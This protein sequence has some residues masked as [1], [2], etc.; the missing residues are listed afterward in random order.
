[1][2][3]LLFYLSEEFIKYKI[4]GAELFDG[5]E[6]GRGGN[7][8]NEVFL[9][10]I[11]QYFRDEADYNN[12]VYYNEKEENYYISNMS[13]EYIRDNYRAIIMAP[14]NLLCRGEKS[15]RNVLNIANQIKKFGIPVFVL[16]LG[17]QDSLDS[18]L[19]NLCNELGECGKEFYNAV[20][21]SGGN[22]AVRGFYTKSYFDSINCKDVK[23]VGCPSM[24]INGLDFQIDEKKANIEKFKPIINGYTRT[25]SIPMIFNAILRN[26]IFIDQGAFDGALFDYSWIKKDKNDNAKYLVNKY[27]WH[28]ALLLSKRKIELF[29]DINMWRNYLQKGD[30]TFSFGERI[31][32]NIISL[33]EGI[34]SAIYVCDSRTLEMAEFFKIPYFEEISCYKNLYEVYMKSDFKEFNKQYKINCQQ[35]INH[36]KEFILI[37]D[38]NIFNK[39]VDC[40]IEDNDYIELSEICRNIDTPINRV[41]YNMIEKLKRI[42]NRNIK[43]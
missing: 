4:Y 23:V 18:G 10:A 28:G 22:I 33:T 6:E 16:G 15:K 34:Q 38:K 41:K 24:Y 21:E 11:F 13:Y 30:Y 43:Y 8:G 5:Y 32:G 26:G 39:V 2:K 29:Y 19:K 35:F 17:V 3:K 31:H 40:D 27:G 20:Y 1:M 36:I 25:I 7:S 12:I 9:S 14:A 42:K 37:D